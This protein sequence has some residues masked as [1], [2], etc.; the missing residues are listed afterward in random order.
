MGLWKAGHLALN[1]ATNDV[2]LETGTLRRSGVVSMKLPNMMDI[3]NAASSGSLGLSNYS[4]PAKKS[5]SKSGRVNASAGGLV[6]MYVS[7]NTPYAAFLHENMKWTPRAWKYLDTGRRPRP[8][9]TKPAVGR[10]KYLYIAVQRVGPQIPALIA[11]E[12][13]A[14]GF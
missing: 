12:M 7:Y 6:K 5:V 11:L 2:P 4:E 1:Y 8:R 10:P 3:Y 9:V 14:Q 13:K